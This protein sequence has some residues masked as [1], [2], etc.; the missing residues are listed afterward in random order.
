MDWE[1]DLH[2]HT[3]YSDGVN[4]LN[5]ICAYAR[6]KGLRRFSITDHNTIAGVMELEKNNQ[7]PE[8]LLYGTEFRLPGLPDFLVYFPT[9]TFSDAEHAEK[10]LTELNR[11]DQEITLAVAPEFI[12]G[13]AKE[14]WNKSS[15]F[16]KTGSFWLGTLQLAQLISGVSHPNTEIISKIRSKKSAIFR[17][18]KRLNAANRLLKM[19]SIDW[20][21]QF[22]KQYRGIIVLAHPFR[23]VARHYHEQKRMDFDFFAE[24]LSN[25]FLQMEKWEICT[26]E[27]I[28]TYSERWWNEKYAFSIDKANR[29]LFSQCELHGT[30]ITIGSDSH[31]LE[32]NEHE[33]SSEFSHAQIC[34][35][36]PAWLK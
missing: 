33:L 12:E 26:T 9:M 2:L 8:S 7:K 27:L 20:V 23:E 28:L 18:P 22:A 24:K 16:N 34:M 36:T 29:H 5:D 15:F 17:N 11:L 1:Y 25:L 30:Q 32:S 6:R 31:N 13:N 10:E 3:T 4:S 21:S 19:A 35:F 14:L